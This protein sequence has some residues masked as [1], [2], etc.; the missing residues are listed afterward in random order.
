MRCDFAHE[1]APFKKKSEQSLFG[2]ARPLLKLLTSRYSLAP[3]L[4]QMP[5]TPP[6]SRVIISVAERGRAVAPPGP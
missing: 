1:R 6:S 3:A 4:P 2:D 5:M